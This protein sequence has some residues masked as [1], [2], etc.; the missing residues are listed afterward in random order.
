[1]EGRTPISRQRPPNARDVYWAS[2]V[3]MMNDIVRP[4]LAHRH[5]QSVEHEFRAQ[6]VRHRP[7]NDLTAT[8]VEHHS[9]IEEAS[10]GRHEGDVGDPE[11]IGAVGGKFAIDEVGCWP[12]IL[13]TSR[14]RR[15]TA[16][17]TG[18]DQPRGTHQS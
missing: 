5:F 1:M 15:A 17:M 3:R 6:V 10:C 14:R 12:S 4:P 13:V 16:S 8:G 2:L 7:A 9:E 11:L 18:A